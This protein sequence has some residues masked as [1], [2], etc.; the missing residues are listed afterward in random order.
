MAQLRT[1]FKTPE[2]IAQAH[3]AAN[4]LALEESAASLCITEADVRHALTNID[5]IWD[6]LY[7][8]EQT[9]IVS[10]L[11]E[12]VVVA[13]DGISVG[14][15]AEGIHSLTVEMSGTE[16]VSTGGPK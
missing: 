14:I 13:P 6:E 10:M 9:R 16:P 15:R 5:S 1:I 7:P 11:V 3:L 4:E 12:R 8:V 2:M